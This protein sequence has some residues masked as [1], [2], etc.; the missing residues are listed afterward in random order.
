[1]LRDQADTTPDALMLENME[2]DALNHESIHRYRI[3]FDNKK[4]G[5]V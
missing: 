4:P 5:H 1:M 2:L 3:L